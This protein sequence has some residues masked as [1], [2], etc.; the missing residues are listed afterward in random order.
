MR[1]MRL[2]I[3]A[4]VPGMPRPL[5]VFDDAPVTQE[6]AEVLRAATRAELSGYDCLIFRDPIDLPQAAEQERS[7]LEADPEQ[8]RERASTL[9][10]IANR[11]EHPVFDIEKEREH[12]AE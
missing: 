7:E 5:L 2:R 8:L 1:R 3:L 9:L 12:G 10:T 4:N 11:L 6:D